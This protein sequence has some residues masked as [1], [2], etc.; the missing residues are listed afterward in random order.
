[1]KI[2]KDGIGFPVSAVRV[3]CGDTF[4]RVHVW[5][6]VGRSIR[7]SLMLRISHLE[8]WCGAHVSVVPPIPGRWFVDT[9]G[10]ASLIVVF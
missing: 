5:R 1:M 6:V 10:G 7:T 8:D 3:V 4:S 9:S 2:V